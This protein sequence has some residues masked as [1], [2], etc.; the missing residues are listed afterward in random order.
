MPVITEETISRTATETTTIT[1]YQRLC[2]EINPC[3]S[4][5]FS[6]TDPTTGQSIDVKESFSSVPVLFN[7][8][9]RDSNNNNK[10][11]IVLYVV[12][13]LWKVLIVGLGWTSLVLGMTTRDGDSP[14][15]FFAFLSNWGVTMC[16][17]YLTFSLMNV[18]LVSRTTEKLTDDDN[19]KTVSWRIFLTW[20]TFIIGIHTSAIATVLYWKLIYDPNETVIK[21]VTISAHGGLLTLLAIDGLL[22][23]R[24]PIRFMHWI[25]VLIPFD[26]L[27]IIWSIIHDLGTNIGNP[28]RNDNDIRTNDDSLYENVL[29]WE[30]NPTTAIKWTIIT[31]FVVGFVLF[32]ILW[33]LSTYICGDRLR[34]LDVQQQQQNKSDED[35]YNTNKHQNLSDEEEDG[36]SN[37]V[38]DATQ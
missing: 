3:K 32:V 5:W 1:L 8:T 9:T 22:L 27:F 35:D 29:E 26:C 24:I 33:T 23:N 30:T 15:F 14:A 38:Y 18:V 10:Y 37:E 7:D 11:N 6:L 19:L 17:I 34:Y 20:I 21:Y 12:T 2:A 16:C 13:I 4:G 25:G 28:D 36:T 31:L